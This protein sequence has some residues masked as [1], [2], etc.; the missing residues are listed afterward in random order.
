MNLLTH[1]SQGVCFLRLMTAALAQR[2]H[3]LGIS[4]VFGGR[5]CGLLRA[6]QSLQGSLLT[7]VETFLVAL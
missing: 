3:S 7:L 5:A 1:G 2:C 4:A 6:F